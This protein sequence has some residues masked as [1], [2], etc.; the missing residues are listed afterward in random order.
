MPRIVDAGEAF[1]ALHL[2]AVTMRAHEPTDPSDGTPLVTTALARM[3]L[4]TPLAEGNASGLTLGA[5]VVLR[6]ADRAERR[7]ADPLTAVRHAR[8][9]LLKYVDLLPARLLQ[10]AMSA[11]GAEAAS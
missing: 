9:A 7:G 6:A 3:R 1:D 10:P 8:A 5:L 4:A 11:A 2:C